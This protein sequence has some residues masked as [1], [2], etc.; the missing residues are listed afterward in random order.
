MSRKTKRDWLQIGLKTLGQ[1]GLEGL[2]ID[3]MAGQLGVTKGSF[4][5]HFHNM[6]DYEEQLLR[7]WASQYL[8]TSTSL[9]T[10]PQDRL[11]LLDHLMQDTFGPI[12]EPEIVIRMWAQQSDLARPFVEQVDALRRQFLWDIF[13]SLTRNE[14]RASL[15]ADMLFT[16]TIGSMTTQP[17]TSPARVL[18]LYGE[19]K[20]L[21]HL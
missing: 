2:T 16:I 14:K 18:E 9:P 15:M 21:Y 10:N 7:Y 17:R 20:R 4:Y 12:T 5:H 13:F 3:K 11:A 6:R 1:K 8:T 19:F